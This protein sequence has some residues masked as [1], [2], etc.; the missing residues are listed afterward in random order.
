MKR[1]L[2]ALAVTGLATLGA[3]VAAI[4]SPTE[5]SGGGEMITIC[6]ATGST[7]NPFVVIT[8]ALNGLNGHA[9]ENHQLSEDIIPPNSGTIAPDGQNWTAD[10]RAT[11]N[12]G[13]VPPTVPPVVPP[14]VVPPVVPPAVVPPVVPGAV[15]PGGAAAGAAAGGAVVANN[16]GFNVQTAATGSPDLVIAPWAGGIAAM[17]L[18]ACGVAV[19]K[20][21]LADGLVSRRRKE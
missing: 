5:S 14:A 8:I 6:H 1:I 21:L 10:G 7:T 18:A 20:S 4:A 12:N 17:L 13:C 19:R 2:A 3:S 9:N 15:V 11:F 16:P